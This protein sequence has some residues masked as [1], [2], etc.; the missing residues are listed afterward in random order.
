[1]HTHSNASTRGGNLHTNAGTCSPHSLPV[2]TVMVRSSRLLP[3]V[4]LS[5]YTAAV[6]RSGG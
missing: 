4:F 3:L 5:A 6:S 1:M 2:L